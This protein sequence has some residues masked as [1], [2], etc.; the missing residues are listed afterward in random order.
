MKKAEI[1]G[2]AS[3]ILFAISAMAIESESPVPYI[4]ITISFVGF[5][6]TAVLSRK[7][8]KNGNL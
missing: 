1:M 6:A 3:M 8:T 7:E 2:M 4:T 5:I